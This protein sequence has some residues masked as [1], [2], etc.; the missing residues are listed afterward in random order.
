MTKSLNQ[1]PRR[2]L[3]LL[4]LIV[5]SLLV[6]GI[7][8]PWLVSYVVWIFSYETGRTWDPNLPPTS[9]LS[10][11]PDLTDHNPNIKPLQQ[12]SV[13]A[14]LDTT[15][16]DG[17]NTI[18]CAGLAASWKLAMEKNH[19]PVE[20]DRAEKIC[21]T[22]NEADKPEAD[23]PP[24]NY[25][26][27]AGLVK[28]GIT[29]QIKEEVRSKFAEMFLPS[30]PGARADSLLTY[31][32]INSRSTFTLPFFDNDEPLVFLAGT[33]LGTQTRAFGIRARDQ[34]G[35]DNLRR[36][37]RILYRPPAE[38]RSPQAYA[39]P[40][41]FALVL[42]PECP[43]QVIVARMDRPH[44]LADGLAKLAKWQAEYTQR[45]PAGRQSF[46]PADVVL[47]P[48]MH[49]QI[50]HV[51]SELL[52]KPIATGP[53]LGLPVAAIEHIRLRLDRGGTELDSQPRVPG[54]QAS[55]QFIV[56][57]PFLLVIQ[58]REARAPYLVLWVENG[59]LLQ[60][61]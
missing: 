60:P 39:Q 3:W 38:G 53:W 49:W 28:D 51:F 41:Q 4:W 1:T 48:G 30:F 2:R 18:W 45:K 17:R 15:L 42:G 19:A 10:G 11:P 37:V 34:Y 36:Q 61:F 27:A 25:Y 47:V 46:G 50:E 8:S 31:A 12:T 13:V 40:D 52:D 35:Y 55:S 7:L 24:G 5:P 59:E 29:K 6:L 33:P 32:C 43:E 23:L 56:D 9:F 21:A 44:S 20:V 58:R 16:P 57:G 54:D 26:A 22:L 14:T